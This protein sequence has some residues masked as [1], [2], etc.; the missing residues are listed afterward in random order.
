MKCSG[1]GRVKMK[2]E[3][4]ENIQVIGFLGRFGFFARKAFP[5]LCSSLYLGYLRKRAKKPDLEYIEKVMQMREKRPLF[6]HLETINRCNGTCSFCPCNKNEDKRKLK[7]MS[8]ELFHKIIDDLQEHDYSGILMLNANCEPFLD[9]RMPEL[10]IEATSKLP[11]AQHILFS[12]GTLITEQIL[13]KIAG[14]LDI[15]YINNYAENYELTESSK[16][17]YD[18]VV[19]HREKFGKMK[20]QIEF[21]YANE[22]LTNKGGMAPNKR[23]ERK[24]YTNPCPNP[25]TE[26]VIYP[27]GVVGLC[28]NDNYEKTNFGNVSEESIFDIFNNQ[29]LNDVREKMR[30]G[31]NGY[32]FCKYCDFSS[33][34]GR[35]ERWIKTGRE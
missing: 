18:Y 24:I 4:N 23:N 12:N 26:T 14:K 7:I 32:E 6:I 9:Q 35:R 10:I 16:R 34:G 1:K 22:V 11:K 3:K 33:K 30:H 21:R 29:K 28:C 27:D 17:I 31:R 20:V 25:Y 8:D 2:Y 5:N 13:E 15:L 19:S